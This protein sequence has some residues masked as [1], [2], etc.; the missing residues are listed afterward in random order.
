MMHPK[1]F[2]S[3]RKAH[4]RKY[5][6]AAI[7]EYQ[8][9]MK[10]SKTPV[11]VLKC[12]L[13]VSKEIPVFAATPNGK[14]IDFVCSHPFGILE[15]KF[16]STKSAVTPLDACADPKFF[17][18][19]VGDHCCLKT[20][21]EYYAQVQDQMAV[22]GASWYDFAVYTFKGMSIQRIS[23]DQEFW[24]NITQRLKLY[25][26]QHFLAFAIQEYKT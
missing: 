13:V 11:V 16:P 2:V 4:G 12:G 23:F 3:R 18:Q 22:T 19:Q 10:V 8:N 24:D 5:E 17:C 26:F 7:L 6:G 1:R 9:L 15:V 21:H 20:D 25:Y 14:V